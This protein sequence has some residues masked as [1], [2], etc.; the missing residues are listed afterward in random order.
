VR[1]YA[2]LVRYVTFDADPTDGD[3]ALLGDV[4]TAMAL[5]ERGGDS[6]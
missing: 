4:S 6:L 5:F 2:L 3:L 1:S